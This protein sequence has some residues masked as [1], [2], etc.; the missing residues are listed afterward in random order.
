MN[1]QISRAARRES[2][3]VRSGSSAGRRKPRHLTTAE[4]LAC[5]VR[6]SYDSPPWS[7]A[8]RRLGSERSSEVTRRGPLQRIGWST[9]RPPHRSHRHISRT[10]RPSS[11]ISERTGPARHSTAA[12]VVRADTRRRGS[13]SRPSDSDDGAGF[14]GPPGSPSSD[15]PAHLSRNSGRRP[16]RAACGPAA[17]AGDSPPQRCALAS[18]SRASAVARAQRRGWRLDCPVLPEFPEVS[19]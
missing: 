15:G 11:G 17:G 3:H 4:P 5:G 10:S 18:R 8:P 6:F 9:W 12:F 2:A 13:Q 7:P 16:A 1:P 19:R 14:S